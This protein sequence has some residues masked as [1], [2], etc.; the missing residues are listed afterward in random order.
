MRKLSRFLQDESGA[1]AIEYVLVTLALLLPTYL[2]FQDL[3]AKVL[4]LM[5]TILR[6]LQ[7]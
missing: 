6:R 2:V 1:E 3:Y 4:L 7:S 5:Q